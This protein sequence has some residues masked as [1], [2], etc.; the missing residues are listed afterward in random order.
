M[1]GWLSYALALLAVSFLIAL[2]EFGHLVAA[3]LFGMKVERYSIGFGPALL[4]TQRGETEYVLSAIPF[5]GY[6]QVMGMNPAE[7][8]YDSDPR[9]YACRSVGQRFL[10]VL[11]GPLTNWL[12][13]AALIFLVA[14]SG[15]PD[16]SRSEV[17]AVLPNSAAQTA[18]LQPGDLISEVDGE[19]VSD[20]PGL[21][22]AVHRHPGETIVLQ[23]TRAGQPMRLTASLPAQGALLGV[24]SPR[25]R[26]SALQ[27]IPAAILWTVR[28]TAE[29]AV[30]LVD[31]FSHPSR[32]QG[33]IRTVQFTAREAERGWESLVS[34]MAAI[35]LALA[36][37]NALPL[38]ALD[39]GRML[40][41]AFEGLFRRPVSHKVEGL[42]HATGFFL[43]IGLIVILSVREIRPEDGPK[44][45]GTPAT[46]KP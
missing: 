28:S 5:G 9:S 15:M 44:P 14:L 13:A 45:S 8:G 38:P 43:L 26:Y 41:L 22:R 18:G 33:P 11:A 19:P 24:E 20:F 10:V 37:F 6:V 27:A 16:T 21:V 4:R 23:L 40:F 31:A 2:H 39:G 7:P 3:R 1:H 36:I 32:L 30:G 42:V 17:G 34:T 29:T 35:S 12:L 46:V 25:R